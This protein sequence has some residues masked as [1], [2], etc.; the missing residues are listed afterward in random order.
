MGL[1]RRKLGRNSA[2][3]KKGSIMKFLEITQEI[4]QSLVAIFDKALKA[5]GMSLLAHIDKVRNAIIV[6][7]DAEPPKPSEAS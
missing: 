5:E 3:L 6:K 1:H 2:R 4:E 7:P